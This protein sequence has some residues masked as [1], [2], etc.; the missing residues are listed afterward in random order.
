MK[1]KDFSKEIRKTARLFGCIYYPF[2]DDSKMNFRQDRAGHKK[3]FD[4]IFVTANG[5]ICLELKVGYNAPREHQA[6][7]ME[8]ISQKN[9]YAF[10][11]R[12]I[13]LKGGRKYR[14]DRVIREGLEYGKEVVLETRD[15]REVMEF[16]IDLS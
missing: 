2:H 16:I 13:E 10:V 14:L 6:K 15:I 9:G 1:E 12:A 3:P 7:A 8:S 4:G 5:N 11:L